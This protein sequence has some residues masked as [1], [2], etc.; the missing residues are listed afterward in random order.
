MSITSLQPSDLSQRIAAGPVVLIDVRSPGEFA[1]GHVPGA[2]NM[3]LDRLDA[4]AVAALPRSGP[5]HVICQGGVRSR[6]AC[7]QLA[8]AG[9]GELVDIT[10]GTSAWKAAGLP[11]EGTGGAVFGVERQVRCIIGGGVLT[12]AVLALTVHPYWAAL[13]GFFGAGLFMAG[14]TNLC[15]LALAVAA[16]PWNRSAPVVAAGTCCAK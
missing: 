13:S 3:P 11:V 10:G 16:M 9:I 4:A 14:L 1:S 8:A 15:P 7:E 5:L 6:K 2:R 12:G